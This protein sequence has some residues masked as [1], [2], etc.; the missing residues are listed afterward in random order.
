MIL[1]ISSRF[2]ATI[3]AA[4]RAAS[5][6][7]ISDG[8]VNEK[9]RKASFSLDPGVPL[10]LSTAG[11]FV[12]MSS[13]HAVHISPST[14]GLNGGVTSLTSTLDQ[15][16]PLKNL[17]FLTFSVP[18]GPE[19]MRLSCCLSSSALIKVTH[20]P[21]RKLGILNLAEQIAFCTA[22]LFFPRNGS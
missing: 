9:P 17:W 16:T 10:A 11:L 8:D 20:S 12:H 18:L 2:L 4:A 1:S 22:G 3:S 14:V 19:P 21:G 7:T 5:A 6:S 13:K 15:L